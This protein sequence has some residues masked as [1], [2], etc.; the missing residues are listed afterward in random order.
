[1]HTSVPNRSRHRKALSPQFRRAG[2]CA[3]TGEGTRP[4]GAAAGPI[5][6]RQGTQAWALYQPLREPLVRLLSAHRR[7]SR[8]RSASCRSARTR[9]QTS[10]PPRRRALT[11]PQLASMRAPNLPSAG[12]AQAI[13]E[14]A[15]KG[16]Q[17]IVLPEMWNCPYGARNLATTARRR[18]YSSPAD[19]P[20]TEN[21]QRM[22][23]SP[24]TRRILA[25]TSCAFVQAPLALLC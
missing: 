11:H 13:K 3:A 16:A 19:A 2:V 10:T 12:A 22:R 5:Q 15:S 21:P 17:L 23:L 18:T 25:G 6:S 7:V 8:W 24:S 4:S 9:L 14:A 20:A 1:M